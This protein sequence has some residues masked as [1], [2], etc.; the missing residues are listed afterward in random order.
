[1]RL[2]QREVRL[3]RLAAVLL[4]AVGCERQNSSRITTDTHEDVEH[5]HRHADRTEEMHTHPHANPQRHREPLHGGRIVPIGHTH[6]DEDVTH[7]YA[8]VLPVHEGAIT[9]YL[10][11]ESPDGELV[12]FPVPTAEFTALVAGDDVA[13]AREVIF[14]PVGDDRTSARFVA[15]VDSDL[16]GRGT[17]TFV[18]PKITLDGNR[19]SFSFPV[20][21]GAGQQD[22]RAAEAAP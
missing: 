10:L 3:L 13:L 16:I 21:L 2:S 6:H 4:V 5:E 11:T 22:T 7:Y 1:M 17:A 12:E 9:L 14:A 19:L 8:E 20:D 15:A 18:V